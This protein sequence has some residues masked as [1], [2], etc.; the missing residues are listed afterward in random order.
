[1][2][3]TKRLAQYLF[4]LDE[5]E[6]V[7]QEETEKVSFALEKLP[8]DD[9]ALISKRYGIGEDR[10]YTL[11]ELADMFGKDR[12]W[13]RHQESRILNTLQREICK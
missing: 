13:V 4:G 7:G 11:K 3:G 9:K 12:E 8:A 10:Q 6:E 2:N 1:M 5:S